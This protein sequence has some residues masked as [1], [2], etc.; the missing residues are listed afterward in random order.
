VLQGRG[1]RVAPRL[2]DYDQ[3]VDRDTL[4]FHRITGPTKGSLVPFSDGS[5]SDTPWPNSS[6]S[7]TFTYLV[8]ECVATSNVTAIVTI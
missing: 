6:G 4:T 1:L 2:R 3:D 8:S 5:F 7:D